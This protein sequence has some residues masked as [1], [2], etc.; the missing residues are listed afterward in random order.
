MIKVWIPLYILQNSL[1]MIGLDL[2]WLFRLAVVWYPWN[3]KLFELQ[4]IKQC[5]T[6]FRAKRDGIEANVKQEEA[7]I[8]NLTREL[9]QAKVQRKMQRAL[10]L[11][12]IKSAQ[13][14]SVHKSIFCR[15]IKP[16][17]QSWN[18]AT[19]FCYLGTEFLRNTK[20]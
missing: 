11:E 17:N 8:V 9:S 1:C 3:Q 15:S 18:Y 5:F 14:F 19:W 6:Y 4:K 2:R 10:H 20:Y 7:N 16:N 12:A 13:D